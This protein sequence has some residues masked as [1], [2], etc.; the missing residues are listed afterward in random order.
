MKDAVVY[1]RIGDY[2]QEVHAIEFHW[3]GDLDK[4][5]VTVTGMILEKDAKERT[6]ADLSGIL[7]I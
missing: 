2:G 5:R 4:S 3:E 6:H 7:G 1:A